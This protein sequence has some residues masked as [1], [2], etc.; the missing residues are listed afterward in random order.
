MKREYS[1]QE[2]KPN[3]QKKFFFYFLDPFWK[4]VQWKRLQ[5]ISIFCIW[6]GDCTH[7]LTAA[8]DLHEAHK[9]YDLSVTFHHGQRKG[10]WGHSLAKMDSS[11][12]WLMDDR[13]KEQFFQGC[14]S[15]KLL[16]LEYIFLHACTWLDLIDFYIKIWSCWKR[17]V[18]G[19]WPKGLMWNEQNMFV[20]IYEILK[21]VH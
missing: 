15:C 2:V 13:E 18:L 5:Q 11:L 19:R 21:R 4:G 6:H 8:M 17:N 14:V 7:K 9:K 10:S 12:G 1:F 16:S 20:F 3:S